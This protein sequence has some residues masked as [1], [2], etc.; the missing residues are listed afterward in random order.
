MQHVFSWLQECTIDLPNDNEN[1]I[2]Y[3]IGYEANIL[4]DELPSLLSI[5]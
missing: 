1:D 3:W 2:F 4:M 5:Q